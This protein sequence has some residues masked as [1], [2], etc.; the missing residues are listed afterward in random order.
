MRMV[1]ELDKTCDVKLK[2]KFKS[3]PYAEKFYKQGDLRRSF[4]RADIKKELL[5]AN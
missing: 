5:V 1:D 3:H 4:K 2:K